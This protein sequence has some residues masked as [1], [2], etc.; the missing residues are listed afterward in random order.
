MKDFQNEVDSAISARDEAVAAAKEKDKRCKTLEAELLQLQE[1]LASS[2]RAR[3]AIQGERD[4]LADELS[5]GGS[6]K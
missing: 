4:E 5:N 1:D 2:E 3:K 6:T